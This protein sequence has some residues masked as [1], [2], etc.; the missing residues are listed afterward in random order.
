VQISAGLAHT[1]ATLRN[2]N[3]GCWGKSGLGE[4]GKTVGE[5]GAS[6][7]A[8]PLPV[9]EKSVFVGAGTDGSCVVVEDK[10]VRCWGLGRD[11]QLG[12]G[13]PCDQGYSTCLFEPRPV[14]GLSDILFVASKKGDLDQTLDE[15]PRE[16]ATCAVDAAGLVFCWGGPGSVELGRGES[17]GDS[18][19]P[20]IV[21]DEQGFTLRDVVQISAGGR[22][23]YALDKFGGVW[24]WGKD[25]SHGQPETWA[26]KR[27]NLPLA[28]KAIGAG[29]NHAC[30]VLEDGRVACWGRNLNG[31]CGVSS[32]N[33]ENCSCSTDQSCPTDCLREPAI[34]KNVA[35]AVGVTAG[36]YHSCAWLA[37]G[38]G[39]CWGNNQDFQVGHATRTLESP[40]TA[41]TTISGRILE[42]AAGRE[43][44]CVLTD[45]G[46]VRCFGSSNYGQA[47][48]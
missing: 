25:T 11:N 9:A 6:G 15:M 27:I 46:V 20:E 26:A 48:L 31:E 16:H 32:V 17:I 34:V 44:T 22:R 12:L 13:L 2:G 37:D 30:A 47:G 3:V 23:M 10:T 33:N 28:A 1:C 45:D 41:L 29:M 8:Q 7:T 19:K 14:A 39:V 24:G 36:G 4:L 38:T 35:G 40:A 43:H 18:T 42:M 5:E 21:V